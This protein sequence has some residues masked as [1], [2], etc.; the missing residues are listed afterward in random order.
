MTNTTYFENVSLL[1]THFNRSRSLERLLSE[2]RNQ[3]ISFGETIVSDGGSRPEHLN[4]IYKLQS[5]FNLTLLT[6]PENKGLGNSINVGQDAARTPYILY[7]QED[8]VPKAALSP[9]L[10]EA[11]SI[12]EREKEWDIVRFYA[13]PWAR[14]PYRKS[15]RNGFS[16]LQFRIAPWFSDHTKFF[17]YSDHP[18][19]KRSSFSEKFGR[20]YETLNGDVT[21]MKMCRA[22]IRNK[23]R[24]LFYENDASL[25]EHHNL[26]GEPG[27]HRKVQVR[28]Q[29]LRQV[30]VLRW[31]YSKFRL[32][33]DTVLLFQNK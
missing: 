29:Q 24:A 16:E 8:F 12:M 30:P 5:T 7:I 14:F 32:L 13:F 4:A 18:H 25:F 28:R 27:M 10:N 11:L 15:Y 21:E 3:R 9:V 17:C 2:L 22:F 19:L 6:T 20:Y 23:G 33:R 1:I 31:A 26:M